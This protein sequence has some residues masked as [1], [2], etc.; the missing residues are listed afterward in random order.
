VDCRPQLALVVAFDDCQELISNFRSQPSQVQGR[1]PPGFTAPPDLV[2]TVTLETLACNTVIVGNSTVL[3][4]TKISLLLVPVEPPGGT[5][6]DQIHLYAL[7]AF[8]E[9]SELA[10]ALSN[11]GLPT[12]QAA[13]AFNAQ[14]AGA[15]FGLTAANVQYTLTLLDDSN[16]APGS[17]KLS[18]NYR[19]HHVEGGIDHWF[20]QT[21]N[22]ELSKSLAGTFAFAGGQVD[23]LPFPPTNPTSVT[24]SLYDG[25]FEW[26]FGSR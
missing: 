25:K 1:L 26:N 6:G 11:V 21:G 3:G 23:G 7:E 15:T 12:A 10:A 2:S 20:N 14:S 4:P 17:L 19:Y 13:I 22:E 9:E 24:S 5:G 16:P 18:D 8:S